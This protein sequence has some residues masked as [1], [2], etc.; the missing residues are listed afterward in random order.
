MTAYI[1]RPH[2]WRLKTSISFALAVVLLNALL[3]TA[4]MLGV[5]V[6]LL[7]PLVAFIFLTFIPGML[8][9][10]ILRIH[11]INTVESIVY[12]A[13]L[14]LAFTMICGVIINFTLPLVNITQ[15]L[16]TVPVT[17]ALCIGNMALIVVAYI[18]DRAYIPPDV[19]R[20]PGINITPLLFLLFLLSFLILGVTVSN[21]SGNNFILLLCIVLICFVIAIAAFG[22]FILPSLFPLAI[23]IVSLCLLYQT[24]L[25]SPYLV[26]TDI[27]VE[28]QVFQQ[29]S[30][31]GIWNYAIPN[32]VNSCLSI[33]MLSPIY[34]QLLN[35]DGIWVFKVIYPLI[36][37]LV[38]LV[39][40]R[41]FRVQ[42]GPYR[43]LFAC[44]LFMAVPTF[45]LEMISLCRQQ[46][47][48][49][50]F[51]LVILLLIDRKVNP[52]PKIVMLTIF[53][54]SIAVSH[55]TLGI[56][57]L[58]YMI[59]LVPLMLVLRSKVF[60]K[61]WRWLTRKTG[62]L[63]PQL[64]SK[65]GGSLPIKIILIP[66]AFFIVFVFI[67]YSVM[68]SGVN[69]ELLTGLWMKYSSRL[70]DQIVGVFV[71]QTSWS[72]LFHTGQTDNLIRA[73]FGMDFMFVSWQG[74]VF[75]ILQYIVQIFIVIGCLRLLFCPRNLKI[76]LEYIALSITS[77]LLLMAC[78]VI[79][80]FADR[81]NTTRWYH[82][83]LIM[84]APFC[85]LGGE[86]MWLAIKSLVH[87]LRHSPPVLNYSD[88][89]P[90]GFKIVFTLIILI[91]YFLAAS[92]FLYE[93][94]GQSVTDK[95]DTPYSIALSSYRI[96]LAGIFNTKDGAGAEWLSNESSTDSTAFTDYHAHK[97][98]MLNRFPGRLQ[99]LNEGTPS[100][101]CFIYLTDWNTQ[102]G[103][104][105]FPTGAGLRRSVKIYQDP[106]LMGY[107]G[108]SNTIYVNDGAKVLLIR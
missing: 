3:V 15:P 9:L 36:F 26:G 43:A 55:Y 78:V 7:R 89:S 56:I 2:D 88:D 87:R 25:L 93:I 84:L 1:L 28:Y 74:Q 31:S 49:L 13:G 106:V 83:T 23:L 48:E 73:A 39:L 58:I 91:P 62:G 98:L 8:M 22:K 104:L 90:A 51:V 16:R 4:G 24:T 10:R 94:T 108:Q 69:L 61:I 44:F 5:D 70:G 96:D 54:I 37:S 14:S 97:I 100:S 76:R 66:F 11:N 77:V 33:A 12:S 65:A 75:R 103:E 6:I 68:S 41:I 71:S 45:S 19:G 63:P 46:V 17:A 32:P 80:G 20:K 92:G 35:V 79:P 67:G 60:I 81:L 40:F 105:T 82:L 101:G 42:F 47:A 34:S 57:S 99:Y 52:I 86:A 38:P 21:I 29:V 59:A 102:K 107:W 50:F 18:R 27:Y 95:V 85:V 72:S 53:M 30:Q 64:D